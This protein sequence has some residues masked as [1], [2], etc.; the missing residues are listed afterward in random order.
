V[1]PFG[2]SK[3]DRAAFFQLAS[4]RVDALLGAVAAA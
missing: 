2:V 1:A 4:M 3:A